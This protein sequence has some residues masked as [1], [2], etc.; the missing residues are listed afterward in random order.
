VEER[1]VAEAALRRVKRSSGDFRKH[2]H[3][4]AHLNF[5]NSPA[6]HFPDGRSFV[7]DDAFASRARF[8]RRF[9]SAS[10]MAVASGNVREKFFTSSRD[11]PSSDVLFLSFL[12][13]SSSRLLARTVT[14]WTGL[15]TFTV[16]PFA[17]RLSSSPFFLSNGV[18]NRVEGIWHWP[19]SSLTPSFY[20]VLSL[21]P[22]YHEKNDDVSFS[23]LFFSAR[24]VIT[25]DNFIYF[26][27][28]DRKF[29]YFSRNGYF[30]SSGQK[31][32]QISDM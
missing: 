19:S 5:S 16:H 21:I 1:R 29:I 27:P 26:V 22:R 3:K 2:L 23:N 32:K 20:R 31:T 11:V 4:R 8:F 6:F 18:V 30:G 25:S 13:L 15:K 9:L 28:D 10:G 12:F 7:R 17:R 24:L 14:M